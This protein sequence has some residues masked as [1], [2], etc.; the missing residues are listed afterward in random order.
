M[1]ENYF[2]NKMRDA[3]VNVR[4]QPK[5]IEAFQRLPEEFTVEDAMRCFS[6][7]NDVVARVKIR[8]LVKDHL[9]EK[10][11]TY[12]ENG[13]TKNKYRKIALMF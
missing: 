4:R 6:L 9:V 7:A 11:A 1:A 8:R 10:V 3:S 2:G 5:T 13:T 12:V